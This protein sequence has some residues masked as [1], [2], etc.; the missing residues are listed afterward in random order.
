MN[1]LIWIAMCGLMVIILTSYYGVGSKEDEDAYAPLVENITVLE[2]WHTYSDIETIVFETQV[3]PLFEEKFPHIK[4]N[5]KRQDY[6]EQLNNNVLASVADN[7][8]PDLMRMD[9]IWVPQ[10][11][12]N[13][14]LVNLSEMKDFTDIKSRFIGTLIETNLY[15]DKYYGLP[16]NANTK[17]AIYNKNLLME[18]GFSEPPETFQQVIDITKKLKQNNAD[19]Y[20][21]GICCSSAWGIMPYY[22]TFGGKISDEK[23]ERASGYL[24]SPESIAALEKIY[25][26]YQEGIISPAILGEEP[27]SWD[28]VFKGKVFMIEEAHWFFT[29]NSNGENKDFLED[30]II[31][32]FPNDVITGT[33]IIGGESLVLFKASKHREEAW[34]FMKWMVTELPQTIMAETGLIPTINDVKNKNENPLLTPYLEQL[35]NARPRPT[36]S[37][38]T[39]IDKEFAKMIERILTNEQSL[40]DAVLHTTAQIDKLLANQ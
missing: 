14:A 31:G 7:K 1:R 35:N 28:G 27:G 12:K 38:W 2:L 6:T 25:N 29:V 20:G 24:D 34:E 18:A 30:M 17:T 3:L 40:E 26:L 15:K 39:E 19:L 10:F 36:V 9:M 32:Q 11:A 16:V 37:T 23:F 8:Q 21:I 33:S 5:A 4:I 22:W 13:G